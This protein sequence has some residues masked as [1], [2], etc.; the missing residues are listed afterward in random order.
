PLAGQQALVASTQAEPVEAVDLALV[1]GVLVGGG[2]ERGRQARDEIAQLHPDVRWKEGQL[3]LPAG[4]LAWQRRHGSRSGGSLAARS[5]AGPSGRA[6][7]AESSWGGSAVTSHGRSSGWPSRAARCR[8]AR[9]SRATGT[10]GSSAVGK[11]SEGAA[12][13][14][15][16]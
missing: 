12:G 13:S 6:L 14:R 8:T 9:S 16:K 7:A 4:E 15:P 3:R 1:S 11:S 2:V 10:S 5:S